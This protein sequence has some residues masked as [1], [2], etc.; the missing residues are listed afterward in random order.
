MK[1]WNTNVKSPFNFNEAFNLSRFRI[2]Q[3]L[4]QSQYEGIQRCDY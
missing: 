3:Y 1:A 4:I 2:K